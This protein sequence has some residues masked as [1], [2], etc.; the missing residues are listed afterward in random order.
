M[1]GQKTVLDALLIFV[2]A[3]C[4]ATTSESSNGEGKTGLRRASDFQFS[5]E[6]KAEFG[7]LNRTSC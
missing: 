5:P 7:D 3:A 1:T 2:K 6:T 4:S